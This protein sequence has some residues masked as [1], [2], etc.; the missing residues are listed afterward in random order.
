VTS[1]D[2]FTRGSREQEFHAL[3]KAC[4]SMRGWSDCYAHL[5]VATGRI[6]AAVEPLVHAWDVAATIPIV[7][8]AG[9]SFTD[10]S[11]V[12]TAHSGNGL[13]SNGSV[14]Q[15]LLDSLRRR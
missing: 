4:R 15:E 1:F 10:W 11:G 5:L 7:K 8:E 6:E 3:C 2:Y 13:V 14:H 12:E 9:G